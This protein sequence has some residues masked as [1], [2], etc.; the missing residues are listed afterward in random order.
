MPNFKFLP[1]GTVSREEIS[2]HIDGLIENLSITRPNIIHAIAN[3]APRRWHH[4]SEII[5][6]MIAKVGKNLSETRIHIFSKR[7][8]FYVK[9]EIGQGDLY[10]AFD[11]YAP[12]DQ[13]LDVETT[14]VNYGDSLLN[15][16]WNF[17][18]CPGIDACRM[19]IFNDLCNARLD[20]ADK[21]NVEL[22]QQYQS[23][24]WWHN[25]RYLDELCSRAPSNFALFFIDH[26]PKP[27]D[28][29][30][31]SIVDAEAMRRVNN[32]E[33]H[34]EQRGNYI[35]LDLRDLEK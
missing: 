10:A 29:T 17:H 25:L 15:Y 21:G 1:K 35:K 28:M 12:I 8:P 22:T 33:Y 7:K 6:E 26:L 5:S 14:T 20:P 4:E 27:Q 18:T 11:K 16:A 3:A 24:L 32:L 13:P 23:S 31:V 30:N 34:A 19:Y 2:E 9:R